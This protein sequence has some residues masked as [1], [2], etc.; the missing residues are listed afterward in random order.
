VTFFDLPSADSNCKYL[1]I[2]E[3]RFYSL[4]YTLTWVAKSLMRA[5]SNVHAGCIWPAGR[6]FP[7]PGVEHSHAQNTIVWTKTDFW[8]S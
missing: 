3:L 4:L 8:L 5:I 6:R 1:L 2:M 7:T